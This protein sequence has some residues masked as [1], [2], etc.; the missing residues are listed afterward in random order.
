MLTKTP[1]KGALILLSMIPL[2]G[3]TSTPVKLDTAKHEE[4]IRQDRQQSQ[5]N[6]AIPKNIT[7]SI[8]EALDIALE[9]NLD[10]RVSAL[11][12]IGAQ[13]SVTLEKI[14]A[15]PT[16]EYTQS[17]V[18]RSNLAASSSRSTI[19]GNQSLEP[20]T[21]SDRYRS[22]RE[23][24]AQLNLIDTATVLLDVKNASDQAEIAK[25]RHKKV[26][27]NIHRDVS[28][29]YWRAYGGQQYNEAITNLSSQ[30]KSQMN[31]ID[32]ATDEKL[33]SKQ[34]AILQKNPYLESIQQLKLLQNE[35]SLA[36]IELKSLLNL[37]QSTTIHLSS[38]PSADEKAIQHLLN[39]DI[40]TLEITAL[41]NRPEMREAFIDK[42]I[43]I[44]DTKKEIVRTL[45]GA[46]LFFSLNSDTNSFLVNDS[47]KSYSISIVQNIANLLSLPDR[48]NIARKNEDLIE[49][50]RT[51]LAAAILA[52]VHIAK[53]NLA[54][55][56]EL[57]TLANEDLETA[58]FEVFAAQKR[59]N[60]GHLAKGQLI[61]TR[62]QALETQLQAAQ[63]ATATQDAYAAFINTL[64]ANTGQTI[65][66]AKTSDNAGVT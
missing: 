48:Y 20:S 16:L 30:A 3:C 63:A 43:S 51:T 39:T 54:H 34:E 45:P 61:L 57:E 1:R 47:W 12:Y 11:E 6:R 19:T 56:K 53:H 29:A 58:Q 50:R 24:S 64:G 5:A 23:I 4:I 62:I 21:S 38:K 25:E 32:I 28:A 42:N 2:Y 26:I 36:S 41:R 15:L 17:R 60:S 18:G 59:Q 22:T 10:A 35:A 46:E 55:A 9:E 40:E 52:Q 14:R 13:D 37:P 66:L 33:I 7:L 31:N 27:Q 49:A 8:D 65:T 44:R